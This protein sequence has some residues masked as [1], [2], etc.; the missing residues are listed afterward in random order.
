[1][2]SL[3]ATA[4]TPRLQQLLSALDRLDVPP[5]QKALA[6]DVA[7]LRQAEGQPIEVNTLLA[8]LDLDQVPGKESMAIAPVAGRPT[9]R[10][11]WETQNTALADQQRRHGRTE[12]W[13][14][15]GFLTSA[16]L[17][18]GNI[19]LD[20]WHHVAAAHGLVCVVGL[21]V[22]PLIW[23]VT[24]SVSDPASAQKDRQPYPASE[25]E[26]G[27]WQAAPQARAYLRQHAQ[28]EVPLLNMDVPHLEALTR[29][30]EAA[31]RQVALDRVLEQ[32]ES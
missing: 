31:Q 20:S 18:V 12:R 16:V 10:A 4:D 22:L 23:S 5:A 9:T 30:H 1:M 21:I 11:E 15:Y 32:Q 27:R 2:T 3:V 26:R 13:T 24:H 17:L 29:A 25:E 6:Q 14:G 19:V 7:R 28:G 8:A